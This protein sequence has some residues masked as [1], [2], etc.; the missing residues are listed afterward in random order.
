M[1]GRK[2]GREL[3][4]EVCGDPQRLD[5]CAG[6]CAEAVEGAGEGD[7]VGRKKGGGNEEGVEAVGLLVRSNLI[8]GRGRSGL[9]GRCADRWDV[10]E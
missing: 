6:E 10:A 9:W 5:V 7:G 4:V 1:G 8:G 2:W 3:V